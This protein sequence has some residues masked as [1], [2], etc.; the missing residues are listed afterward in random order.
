MKFDLKP[1]WHNL[2]ESGP[3][4]DGVRG[5]GHMGE[6]AFAQDDLHEFLSSCSGRRRLK[7]VRGRENSR[8]EQWHRP[9]SMRIVKG[10]TWVQWGL[11][12]LWEN[13]KMR[14]N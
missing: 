5:L 4:G 1:K 11:G 12:G 6:G 13:E 10:K 7:H 3:R 2:D 8:L 9:S 14:G